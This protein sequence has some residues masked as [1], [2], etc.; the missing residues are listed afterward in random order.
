MKEKI[1]MKDILIEKLRQIAGLMGG[2][3]NVGLRVSKD[4]YEISVI[5]GNNF[6]K[7]QRQEEI[8]HFIKEQLG[9]ELTKGE[10]INDMSYIG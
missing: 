6:L 3:I 1:V 2:D 10:E 8:A 5:Q 9:K 7:E 4:K